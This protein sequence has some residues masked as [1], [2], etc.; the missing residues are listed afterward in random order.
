[1]KILNNTLWLSITNFSL[2][3]HRLSIYCPSY[4]H[5]FLPLIMLKLT[6]YPNYAWKIHPLTPW[7]GHPSTLH[8][9]CYAPC[10]VHSDLPPFVLVPFDADA[11]WRWW[12]MVDRQTESN[13]YVSCEI[14]F[15]KST[16][17]Y[18]I[19]QAEAQGTRLGHI[20]QSSC[21]HS[22]QVKILQKAWVSCRWRC[23]NLRRWLHTAPGPGP[24]A[25]NR[26]HT[27]F[28]SISPYSIIHVS[29][30][31]MRSKSILPE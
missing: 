21:Q 14:L 9:L 7:F 2:H 6:C 3:Y 16:A 31:V 23:G 30:R 12:K 22:S 27:G 18:Y 4:S 15:F 8:R 5:C 17:C 11:R 24:S 10:L 19:R 28:P 29:Q 13:S 1:V 26:I 20:E 25:L